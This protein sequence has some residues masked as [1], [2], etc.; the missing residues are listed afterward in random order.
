MAGLN[1]YWTGW[2]DYGDGRGVTHFSASL[3]DTGG[4]LEGITFEID[5]DGRE[6]EAFL[7]G[8]RHAGFAEFTKI[9]DADLP[10]YDFPVEYAGEVNSAGTR[11]TG[12]WM[13]EGEEDIFGTAITFVGN[14]AMQRVSP[15]PRAAVE[16]KT[17]V[18]VKR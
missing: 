2:Y 13:I 1:G 7:D 3:S 11:I 6:L 17:S 16:R 5:S 14:F 4:A 9:Y 10:G 8:E 18:E 15:L 12:Q